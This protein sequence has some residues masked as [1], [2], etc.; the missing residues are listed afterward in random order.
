MRYDKFTIRNFH[1][2]MNAANVEF[3]VT[4][5]LKER[6]KTFLSEGKTKVKYKAQSHLRAN[7]AAALNVKVQCTC[8]EYQRELTHIK[9][10][11]FSSLS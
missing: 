7:W 8:T 9:T 1:R 6:E 5:R 4:R 2:G 11:I 10:H 3:E